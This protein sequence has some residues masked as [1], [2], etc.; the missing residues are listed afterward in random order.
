MY[1]KHKYLQVQFGKLLVQDICVIHFALHST[2][3][4]FRNQVRRIALI[5]GQIK[6]NLFI[7]FHRP[8]NT[9]YIFFTQGVHTTC[10]TKSERK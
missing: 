6:L 4:L 8:Y 7:T 5:V 2:F 3:R 9:N 10:Y 1:G